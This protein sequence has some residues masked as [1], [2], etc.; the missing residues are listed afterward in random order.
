MIVRMRCKNTGVAH[1]SHTANVLLAVLG[2]EAQ[3]LVEA[4]ADVVAVQAEGALALLEQLE[5]ESA[6]E[7]RLARS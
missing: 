3:V 7:G 1:L 5:L 2:G 4:E 6:G